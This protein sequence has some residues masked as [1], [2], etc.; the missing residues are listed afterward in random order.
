VFISLRTCGGITQLKTRVNV[1]IEIFQEEAEE[2][3]F[4]NDELGV[5]KIH[6][7]TIMFHKLNSRNFL[8]GTIFTS[9]SKVSV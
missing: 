4:M 7:E 8:H 6:T 5:L 3:V 9:K 2:A 1:L